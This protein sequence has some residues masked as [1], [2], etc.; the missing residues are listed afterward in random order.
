[1]VKRDPSR[2]KASD[3]SDLD[4]L[5]ACLKYASVGAPFPSEPFLSRFPGKVI[6]QKFVKLEKRGLITLKKYPTH[7]GLELLAKLEAA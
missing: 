6:A 2:P 4:M 3:I 5:A 7:A 1:M